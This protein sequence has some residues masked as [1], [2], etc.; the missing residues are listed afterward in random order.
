MSDPH[1]TNTD[2][3]IDS[4]TDPQ[5][6]GVEPEVDV[7]LTDEELIA[8]CKERVCVLCAEK[9]EADEERLRS[10]AEMDNFKKRLHREQEDFRKY[11]AES[12]LADLLPILDNL[13][14]AL[15]HAGDDPACQ[16]IIVGVD[17]TRKVFLDT[18]RNHGLTP[19]GEVGET[20]NPE[21]HE[22][23]GEDVRVDMEPGL[24]SSLHQRGYMLRERLLRPARVAV[25]K[26]A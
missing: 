8:L 4:K 5:T 16:N 18:L 7:T 17:M 24:V 1:D 14:L 6:E 15:A 22:A 19:L 9:E 3:N 2:P 21:I 12:V 25:S 11:A 10:L 20:F 23:V 13:D 26:S